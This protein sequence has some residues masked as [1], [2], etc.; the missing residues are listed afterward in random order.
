MNRDLA[1]HQDTSILDD[2]RTLR[3]LQVNYTK[4][5]EQDH[6]AKIDAAARAFDYA[7]C[8][9][10]WWNP[11]EYSLLHGTPLWEQASEAQR[12]VL[13]HLYWV[14]YYAQIIS[15]EIATIVL[16]QT[17]AAGLNTY[18]DFRLVCDTLDLETAQERCH[19]E[20]FKRI[21][22]A[23][24]QALFG[25]RMFTYPMRSMYAHTMLYADAGAINRFWRNIQMRAYAMLS[26]GNAFIGCQYFTVRGIRTLNGKMIQHGLAQVSLKAD[27]AEATP[28]PSRI[29]LYH[30]LDESFHFNSSRILT[31]D[32]IRSLRAPTRFESWVANRALEGCQRDH[33]NVTAAIRGIFWYEPALLPTVA[34]ILRSPLFG[35]EAR[36]AAAMLWKC[37]G[38]ETDGL[39][40]S[41]RVHDE[42]V[43]SYKAY[44]DPLGYVNRA[45]HAMAIM[46]G[47]N[48]A[49]HL[50][51]N[52]RALRAMAA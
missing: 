14:A 36:E 46:S 19:I 48:V 26:S 24:E 28:I 44:L 6:S 49:R 5:R 12:L 43:A 35:M 40:A 32:V 37:F 13:N 22:E 16:N 23:V 10:A 7:A 27:D 29:S 50:R 21:G 39:H 31:H 41:F 52:R 2:G 25:E 30:F 33:F 8:R 4:N 45:N 3:K 1:Q 34:R 17:S 38:E 20:A 51:A 47:N 9:D 11:P 15:A 18:E 42:A